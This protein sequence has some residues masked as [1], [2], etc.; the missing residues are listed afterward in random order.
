MAETSPDGYGYLSY[1]A[2]KK[3]AISSSAR[4]AIECPCYDRGLF[5]VCPN[6]KN[7]DKYEPARQQYDAGMYMRREVYY[8]PR[9]VFENRKNWNS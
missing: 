9:E 6:P 1:E 7:P 5:W 8:I 2:V 4:G 3:A